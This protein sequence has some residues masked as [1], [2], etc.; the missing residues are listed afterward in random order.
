MDAAK[1]LGMSLATYKEPQGIF[2]RSKSDAGFARGGYGFGC[3]YVYVMCVCDCGGGGYLDESTFMRS[4][5]L[6]PCAYS[7]IK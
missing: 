5:L 3:M 1:A 7:K 4:D 6:S 2:T